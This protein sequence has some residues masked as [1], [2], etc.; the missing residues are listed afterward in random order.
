M[1]DF[2][3]YLCED[4][5]ALFLVLEN[6]CNA[7]VWYLYTF[8]PTQTFKDTFYFIQKAPFVLAIFNFL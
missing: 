6:E 4:L 8:Y 2:F 3:Y 1:S 5:Q 7:F